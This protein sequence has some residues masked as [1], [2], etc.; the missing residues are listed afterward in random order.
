MVKR[1]RSFSLNQVI[2]VH[3]L[4]SSLTKAHFN[5]IS[6]PR[7]RL[8]NIFFSFT[9]SS[10]NLLSHTRAMYVVGPIFFYFVNLIIF[11]EVH[12][13]RWYFSGNFLKLLTRYGLDGPGIEF[14][15]RWNLPHLSRSALGPNQPHTQWVLGLFL[16]VKRP[17][18]GV[19][20][21]THL[22]PRLRKEHSYNDNALV[23]ICGLF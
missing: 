11:G 1:Q 16:G 5:I 7:L 19:N 17:G 4:I 14:L 2:P 21:P 6:S 9:F 12:K 18:H 15:R 22:P 23:D 13:P 3:T 10:T 20:Y 8:T